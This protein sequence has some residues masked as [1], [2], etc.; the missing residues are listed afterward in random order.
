MI[1]VR[2]NIVVLIQTASTSGSA[3]VII[4]NAGTTMKTRITDSFD[5]SKLECQY[6]DICN[7]YEPSR[8]AYSSPCSLRQDI[9]RDLESYVA[10]SNLM[11]QI[12]LIPDEK[13]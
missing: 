8:C 12:R 10:K 5:L 3:L 1:F 9:R 7:L 13:H 6:F 4:I 2:L 11:M